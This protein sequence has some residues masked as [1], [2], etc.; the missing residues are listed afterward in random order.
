MIALLPMFLLCDGPAEMRCDCPSVFEMSYE[1]RHARPARVLMYEATAS[2]GPAFVR[3]TAKILHLLLAYA[4]QVIECC[5]CTGPQGCPCCV[6]SSRCT[7]MNQVTSKRDALWLARALE[8]WSHE[9][10]LPR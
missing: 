1:Q 8:Q 5:P 10:P 3:A 7:E 6:Q 9:Y 4:R 2:A